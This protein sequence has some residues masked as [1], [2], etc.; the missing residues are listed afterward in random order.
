MKRGCGGKWGA[1]KRELITKKFV[2]IPSV[3]KGQEGKPNA[4]GFEQK[5][6][7]IEKG[8]NKKKRGEESQL[9]LKPLK[10][11]DRRVLCATIGTYREHGGRKKKGLE[12]LQLG[13]FTLS[14]HT[15]A[16][17]GN[18]EV[19]RIRFKAESRELKFFII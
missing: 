19:E 8:G 5:T 9:P 1:A 15:F 4:S 17:Q 14:V 6:I 13:E 11:R 18:V 12:T 10:R 3:E 16:R 2:G 7:R